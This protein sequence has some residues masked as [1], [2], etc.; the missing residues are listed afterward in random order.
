MNNDT[1]TT[2]LGV[3]K[4]LLWWAITYSWVGL[5]FHNPITYIGLI[6]GIVDVVQGYYTNKPVNP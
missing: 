5:N 3:G 1:K 4:G 2:V 6:K